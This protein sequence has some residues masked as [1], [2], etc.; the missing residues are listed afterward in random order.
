MLFTVQTIIKMTDLKIRNLFVF[1]SET[2][3]YKR[4]L[5]EEIEI[6]FLF[7]GVSYSREPAVQDLCI[8]HVMIAERP[9]HH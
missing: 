8:T 6:C 9:T 5:F 2:V 1:R 4:V 7:K 3:S